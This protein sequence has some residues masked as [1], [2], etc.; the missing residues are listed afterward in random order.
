MKRNK[1]R[2]G[3][4]LKSYCATF[5]T[6]HSV[7]HGQKKKRKHTF[8]SVCFLLRY[9]TNILREETS[10][11]L[12]SWCFRTHC[13]N[14]TFFSPG[15]VMVCG[16]KTN[17]L[18]LS[19]HRLFIHSFHKYLLSTSCVPGSFQVPFKVQLWPNR[20]KLCLYEVYILVGEMENK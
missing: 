4:I 8:F 2:V 3:Y 1:N 6:E 9:I 10:P 12:R 15:N 14:L 19:T 20:A 11:T 7:L 5:F 13:P 16:G 17:Y 18:E